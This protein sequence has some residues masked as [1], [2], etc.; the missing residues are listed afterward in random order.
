MSTPY[1]RLYHTLVDDP[2]FFTVYDHDARFATWVRLLM[3]ADAAYPASAP[4]PNGVNKAVLR[5]LV[6]VAGLVEL[7]P[8]GRYRIHGMRKERQSRAEWGKNM[9]RSRGARLVTPLNESLN[10]SLNGPVERG[11]SARQDETR[12]EKD[13]QDEQR[14]AETRRAETRRDE[15]RRAGNTD[16]FDRDDYDAAIRRKWEEM[17]LTV[18]ERD[19][20]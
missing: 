6:E 14:P 9:A 1:S 18:T 15:T 12:Q 17:G 10:E 4:L 16:Y 5:H 3:L 8:G 2:R 7:V 13:R 20:R 11:R 19:D